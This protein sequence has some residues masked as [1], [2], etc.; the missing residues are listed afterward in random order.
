M[1][2]IMC[3]IINACKYILV[4]PKNKFMSIENENNRTSLNH[5]YH[6]VNITDIMY[7]YKYISIVFVVRLPLKLICKDPLTNGVVPDRTSF[8]HRVAGD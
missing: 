2:R 6:A 1:G 8:S 3:Y 4:Y 7:A 5:N